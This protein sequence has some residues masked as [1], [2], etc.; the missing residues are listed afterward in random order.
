MVQVSNG[1]SP[2]EGMGVELERR[3]GNENYP[4]DSVAVAWLWEG[5]KTET[6][7]QEQGVVSFSAWEYF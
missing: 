2:V 5:S 1:K 6:D 3:G 7:S 4:G